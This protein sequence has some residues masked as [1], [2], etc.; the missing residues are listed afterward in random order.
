LGYLYIDKSRYWNPV[1]DKL[2]KS[3]D[4]TKENGWKSLIHY[5]LDQ[6]GLM[7]FLENFIKS[8]E[9]LAGFL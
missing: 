8:F 2:E 5:L 4:I 3:W 7:T 9:T 6:I 1:E